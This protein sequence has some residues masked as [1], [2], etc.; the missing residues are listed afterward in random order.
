[1]TEPKP[2]IQMTRFM[3][4]GSFKAAFVALIAIALSVLLY[5]VLPFD[6]DVNKG[7]ALLLFVA[8]LWFSEVVHI[9]VTALMIP[10]I[11]VVL[12]FDGMSTKQ[13]LS[14]FSD[15]VIFIF[16]GGFA[17]AT[18]LHMQ[19]LDR[20]IA[21]YL[22]SLARGNMLVASLLIF[23]VTAFLSMWISNTAT[24]AMMLP[25]ALGV[26]SHLDRANHRNSYVFVLLGVAYSASIGG[27]GTLV[28]SPPNAI[29]ARELGMDFAAWMKIGLPMMLIMMPIMI[30]T[31]WIVFRPNFKGEAGKIE[32]QEAVEWT[33]IRIVTAL[34]FAFI[35]LCWIFSSKITQL[36]GTTSTDSLI[37]I[38]AAV[39]VVVLGCARWQDVVDNTDWG[40]LLLFGGGIALSKVMQVSGASEVLGQMVA[41]TFGGAN[42]LLVIFIVCI[43]IIILTEFTSN[44][45]SA[46]LL[47]PVF[48]GVATQMNLPP[49]VLVLVIGIGA[50]CAFMMPVA[51]PPNAIVFGSGLIRQREMIRAG[52]VLNVLSIVVISLF[53]YFF[54]Y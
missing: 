15:P 28:G 32:D 36:L 26:M 38:F 35:A 53:V 52:L 43:F 45:A 14:N 13:A 6:S 44:T 47:V 22:V 4:R 40:V 46:A 7:L 20:K 27:L 10:I 25:L 9:S 33:P 23:A 16:F 31:L 21:F 42:P 54:I 48:A 24:A 39:M 29:T 51:T 8:I 5:F 11:A 30:F 1:M 2:H 41:D 34:L 12:G 19:K 18:A 3:P 37:A 49:E 17:L 50:S